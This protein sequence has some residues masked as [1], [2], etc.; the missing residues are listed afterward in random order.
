LETQRAL[1][2]LEILSAV[3]DNIILKRNQARWRWRCAKTVVR[4]VSVPHPA[5]GD[6][7]RAERPAAA[8]LDPMRSTST[9]ERDATGG[10]EIMYHRY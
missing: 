8:P 7:A 2:E 10:G 6:R 5:R 4:S 9:A 3:A 1:S